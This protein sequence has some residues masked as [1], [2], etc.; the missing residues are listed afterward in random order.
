MYTVE[1]YGRI[2]RAVLVEGK[3]ERA[4][5]Q[6]FGITDRTQDAA[7]VVRQNVIRQRNERFR[8]LICAGEA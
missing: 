2:R 7:V 5:A 4:V 8:G 3:S 1:I 6:E